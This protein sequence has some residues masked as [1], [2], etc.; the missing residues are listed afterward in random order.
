MCNSPLTIH[1][2]KNPTT[3]A[4]VPSSARATSDWAIRSELNSCTN[5][6]PVHGSANER[7]SMIRTS[8]RSLLRIASHTTASFV[9][10][11]A[12]YGLP[13]GARKRPERIRRGVST[14][15]QT[16]EDTGAPAPRDC[17]DGRAAAGG[18]QAPPRRRGVLRVLPAGQ[19]APTPSVGLVSALR[20]LPTHH[21][22]RRL[23]VQSG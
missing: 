11:M 2:H 3:C 1:A 5:I 12:L 13:T 6:S 16:A 20:T 9:L 15:P 4:P 19:A 7:L 14:L 21:P 18:V 10:F 8:G 17:L 23:V 22:G